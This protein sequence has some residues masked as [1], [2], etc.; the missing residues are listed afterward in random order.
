MP[1]LPLPPSLLGNIPPAPPRA[2]MVGGAVR[3]LL[4]QRQPTDVDIVVDGDAGVFAKTLAERLR[5]SV[6]AIGKA[7]FVTH[8]IASRDML[9]DI[10]SLAGHTLE[11]DLRRR[12]FTINAMAYDLGRHQLIDILGGR[13]DITARRIRMVSEQAFADDPLRLLRAFR[14]AAVLDFDIAPETFEVITRHSH[15]IDRP[16]GERLRTE[17]LRLMSCPASVVQIRGMSESGLLVR[18]IP[19]LGPLRGC[20]QNIHHD[21]DVYDHTLKAY[22][23]TEDCLRDAGS[24]CAALAKRYRRPPVHRWSIAILKYAVLL[25]DIGKPPTRRVDGRGT[26]RFHGHARQSAEMAESVHDRLRLSRTEREQARR[27]IANHGRP[28]N[29][30]SAHRGASLSRKG[31]N[32]FFRDCAPWTPEVLVHALGDALGKKARPDADMNV[33]RHFI[34]DLLCDYFDR[35]RPLAARPSLVEG[36]DLMARFAL[37]PSARIGEVLAA[38]EE[39]RLAGR[40]A[41]RDEALAYAAEYLAARGTAHPGG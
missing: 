13:Q 11:N 2:Y 23:G 7:G 33:T 38:V 14:L 15:R 17:L 31:I 37:R 6:A 18:L 28:M 12:D 40:I 20:G 29:L 8:R 10:T 5:A 21:F 26:V 22:A 36:R 30:L 32:R 19:E 3:D 24:I 4:M 35:F 25:H 34:R 1:R 41:T 9:I 27:I 16:A 39:E